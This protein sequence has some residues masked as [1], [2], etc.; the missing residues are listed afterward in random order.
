MDID[1]DWSWFGND[2]VWWRVGGAGIVLVVM[3]VIYK[4]VLNKNIE[5]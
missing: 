4:Y 1:I 3:Y 2:M 5:D